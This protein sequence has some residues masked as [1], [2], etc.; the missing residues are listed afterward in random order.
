MTPYTRRLYAQTLVCTSGE[1]EYAADEGADEAS[2]DLAGQDRRARVA[3]VR[4]RAMIPS[5]MSMQRSPRSTRRQRR[6]S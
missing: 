6:W 5:L 3:I 1:D 2:E 4:N